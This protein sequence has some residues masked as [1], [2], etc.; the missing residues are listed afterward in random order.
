MKVPF[1][2]ACRVISVVVPLASFPAAADPL[3][4]PAMSGVLNANPNP[5]KFDAGPVGKIY[6]TGVASGIA[7]WQDHVFPGDDKTLADVSNGQVFVQKTDGVLQFFV[8]AGI[9]S[10][11]DLG[12]PY[13]KATDTTKNLYGALPQA[14]IK[15]APN[16]D[17]SIMVGKLPTLIGAE[18]T[19]SFENVNVER[20][21]LWNQETAVSRG[22]Q[23]NYAHGPLSLSASLNDGF[24]SNRYNWLSG[25]IGYTI[26]KENSVTL[27]GGGNLGHTSRSTAATP[28]LQNNGEIYNLIFTHTAGPWLI[29]P[30]VQYTRVHREPQFGIDRGAST[31]GAALLLSYAVNKEFH[32]AGRA[33]YI[34]SS[35]SPGGST[36]SLLYG[37][38]SR[39]WSLTV[40]PTYQKGILFIRGEASHVGASRVTPG[41][42][43]GQQLNR[44]SQNRLL[45]EG[46]VLF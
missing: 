17:F 39:A 9:Y 28:I 5:T 35:G 16:S 25:S 38:G 41:F 44:K 34:S 32:L 40:T 46:G 11:P 42:G 45:V 26:D 19:F 23:V 7:Q 1:G 37:P 43:F 15:I 31:Y 20:G 36:P 30:Y 14:F 33:E 6:V 8:E 18:Y 3:A 21:L 4:V 10:L 29:Q 27:V 12:L 22:V 2:I 24:Y 13:V